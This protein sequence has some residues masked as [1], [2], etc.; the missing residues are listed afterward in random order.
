MPTIE[1]L[2]VAA[3]APDTPRES[4]DGWPSWHAEQELKALAVRHRGRFRLLGGRQGFAT[5]PTVARAKSF[6]AALLQRVQSR[7][8]PYRPSRVG[9]EVRVTW[10]DS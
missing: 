1:D 3:N 8:R 2:L 4:R 6:L 7:G 10:S 9:A 5:F